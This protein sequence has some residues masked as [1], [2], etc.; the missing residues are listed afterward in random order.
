MKT[1][2]LQARID[3]L[4]PAGVPRYVRCYSQDSGF[5]RHTI[6]FTGR[7]AVQTG[8]DGYPRHFPYV[9]ESGHGSTPDRACDVNA[10]GWAPAMGR[11]NHLGKRVPWS[12]IPEALRRVAL[13]DYKEI[14]KLNPENEQVGWYFSSGPGRR[15]YDAARA[16]LQSLSQ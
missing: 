1:K 15:S 2:T 6:V 8:P 10:G 5:D 4:M 13:S 3:R 14:W 7:S 12:E 16:A 11:R 9:G